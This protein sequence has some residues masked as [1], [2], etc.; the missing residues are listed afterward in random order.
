MDFGFVGLLLFLTC[1]FAWLVRW[2]MSILSALML[3]F[4]LGNF[5]L[6]NSVLWDVWLF[7]FLAAWWLVHTGTRKFALGTPS[8]HTTAEAHP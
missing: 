1:L 6:T 7:Y 4:L 8:T 5:A 3:I 2:P